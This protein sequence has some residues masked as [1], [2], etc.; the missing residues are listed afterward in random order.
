M[1]TPATATGAT[2]AEAGRTAAARRRT[3]ACVTGAGDGRDWQ[4]ERRAAADA[5]ARALADREARE[6]AKARAMLAEF[7]RRARQRGLEPEPL[8][9]QGYGGK[10]TAKSQVKGWY[11]RVDRSVGVGED[12]EFYVLTAP[13][14]LLDRVR[15][16]TVAP[17]PPPL[18]IGRGSGDGDSIDL[19][20]A[21]NR[22][23][24][25]EPAG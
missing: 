14:T 16:V 25:P 13:L 3:L 20:E 9:V 22:A 12:G 23:L 5:H 1:A 8:V 2:S 17:K 21:I 4:A 18:V 15:G 10:G 19:A 7:V 6:S 11:L 24:P